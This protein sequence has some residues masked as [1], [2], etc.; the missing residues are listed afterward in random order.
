MHTV[1]RDEQC[2]RL[3][4]LRG[5]C[6][7]CAPQRLLLAE[8]GI[9]EPLILYQGISGG[10]EDRTTCGDTVRMVDYPKLG[11]LENC[12]ELP[13]I[14]EMS[15]DSGKATDCLEPIAAEKGVL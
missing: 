10:F 15:V 5:E 6:C 7:L 11:F 14:D 1:G 8:I 4:Q 13:G 9:N 12:S 2:R 3:R